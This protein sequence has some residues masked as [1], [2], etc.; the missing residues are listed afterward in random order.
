MKFKRQMISLLSRLLLINHHAHTIQHESTWRDFNS[1]NSV[2]QIFHSHLDKRSLKKGVLKTRGFHL[3]CNIRAKEFN[4]GAGDGC[5]V[6]AVLRRRDCGIVRR[7][8]DGGAMTAARQRQRDDG[9]ATTVAA[10]IEASGIFLSLKKFWFPLTL[11]YILWFIAN[12]R[13][14][15]NMVYDDVVLEKE[16]GYCRLMAAYEAVFA[17]EEGGRERLRSRSTK[18]FRAPTVLPFLAWARTAACILPRHCP[19]A[20]G[21]S[22]SWRTEKATYS[23]FRRSIPLQAASLTN[24]NKAE[25]SA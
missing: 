13:G 5:G 18:H 22:L 25:Y 4:G 20:A 2:Y 11:H 21:G 8:N 14:Q 3:T 23:G 24:S 1:I 7:R 9:S 15:N 16:T 10:R 19:I 6:A 12:V 17:E